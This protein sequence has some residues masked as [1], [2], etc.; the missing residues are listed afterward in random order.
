MMYLMFMKIKA[1]TAYH[2]NLSGHPYRFVIA[3][4]ARLFVIAREERLFVFAREA[5]LFVIAREARLFDIARYA[6]LFVIA[7]EAR[8]RQSQQQ[9]SDSEIAALAC[10]R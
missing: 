7:R 1:F 6:R 9:T 10:L 8:P 3:R 2:E 5:L 4:K